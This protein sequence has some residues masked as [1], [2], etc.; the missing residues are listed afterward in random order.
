MVVP[1]A[2]V[3]KMT[4]FLVAAS[5]LGR[6]VRFD[7]GVGMSD[8]SCVNVATRVEASGAAGIGS[9]CGGARLEISS[10]TSKD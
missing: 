1:V 5:G 6:A 3:V 10:P 9:E 8:R 4:D 7:A 2:D